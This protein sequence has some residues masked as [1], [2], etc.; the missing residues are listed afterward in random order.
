M[1][2]RRDILIAAGAGAIAGSV[3]GMAFARVDTDARFVLVILRGAADG[4]AIAPPFGDGNYRKVRGEL[5]MRARMTASTNSTACSGCTRAC[6][7]CSTN[8]A[9]TG[10]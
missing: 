5:A 1:I 10:R 4:L 6:R 9:R 8:F 3:P 7:P 2:S